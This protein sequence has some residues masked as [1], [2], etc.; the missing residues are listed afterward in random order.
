MDLEI[1]LDKESI[2]NLS[3]FIPRNLSLDWREDFKLNVYPNVAL[4]D[5]SVRVYDMETGELL[6]WNIECNYDED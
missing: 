6:G 3:Y 1:T 4:F 2:S 5:Q